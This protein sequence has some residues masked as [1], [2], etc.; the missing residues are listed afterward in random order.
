MSMPTGRWTD[1]SVKIIYRTGPFYTSLFIIYIVV[2]VTMPQNLFPQQNKIVGPLILVHY[3][4]S[5]VQFLRLILVVSSE[6]VAK[7]SPFCLPSVCR[8]SVTLVRPTQPVEI[9]GNFSSPFGTLAIH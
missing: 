3:L 8:L 7:L 6:R 2:L 5:D 1:T 4:D 9:F